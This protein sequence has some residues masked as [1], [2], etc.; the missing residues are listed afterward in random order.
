MSLDMEQ[1]HE[2]FFD[3]TAE[4]LDEME[5]LLMALDLEQPDAGELDSIFRAA[6]S[7]KGGS[8]IFGFEALGTVTHVMENLLD[9]ARDGSL[10]LSADLMDLLL[11]TGDTLRA[12]LDA[13]RNQQEPD[14]DSV[15]QASEALEQWLTSQQPST[16]NSGDE[17]SE[18]YGFFAAP[19]E[20][21][22]DYEAYGFFDETV[23]GTDDDPS[24][25]FFEPV[26]AP[27]EEG[28][29]F[30]FF[31]D[32]T[33]S[34]TA[35]ANADY[36]N[37]LLEDGT[38]EAAQAQ[39]QSAQSANTKP[40]P[41]DPPQAA[42]SGAATAQ[43]GKTASTT[44]DTGQKNANKDSNKESSS[45]RVDIQKVDQLINLVGEM[46]ITQ[47]MLQE[48]GKQVEGATGERLESVL[49]ELE[50]NTRE[51]QESVMAVRMLPISFAFSRFP[52]VVRDL[53]GKLG[54]K[55][56]L[57]VEGGDTELDKG[58]IE[59]LTDPLTHLVR[60]SV[61]HGVES[62]ERRREAGKPE[63]GTVTLRAIQ[64]GGNVVVEIVD[65][66]GGLNRDKILEKAMERGI[67]VPSNP[68]DQ[69]VWSL[70]M[71]PGFSTADAVSDVSGRGVGMDVVR[72][73]LE[74]LGGRVDIQSEP[75]EGTSF[76][77]HLPLTLAIVDGMGVSVGNETFIVPLVN[78]LESM[79][80][81]S[82]AV[83]TL[84]GTDQ[85]LA[86]RDQFWP[87]IPLHRVMDVDE[88]QAKHPGEGI[89]VLVESGRRR[90]ALQVD[91][92]VGQQQVVIK[93][94]EQNYRRVPG[95]AG[96]TI[97]GDGSVALILDTEALADLAKP[98]EREEAASHE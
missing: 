84:G 64:H 92:L 39:T 65:D 2:S 62:P 70:V 50:R 48:I 93:S 18:G 8:G 10:A 4:H 95:I 89:M 82:G 17:Q 88:A 53:S 69:A 57:V 11:K 27:A 52:R 55:V 46:V 12:I 37:S 6:H 1:F 13:Y 40:E 24:F 76:F 96:A 54:K 43:S 5:R 34:S 60:N 35:V 20:G 38:S 71:E 15:N 63:T 29:A 16:E 49:N 97:M 85:L 14:W 91:D 30:G 86:V 73:N 45:I 41:N 75:G 72:Q 33:P 66:G 36:I 47:S 44:P 23:Q 90:F 28:D 74:A 31:E 77:I 56:Q 21:S 3:E 68:S 98:V 26:E 51:L 87:V 19:A 42:T 9:R 32:E 94:L 7:I 81:E 78:I 79:A 80:P 58:L 61:D 25:G 83:R 22:N 67:D 59:K